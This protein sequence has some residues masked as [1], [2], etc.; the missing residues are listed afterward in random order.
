MRDGI[1]NAAKQGKVTILEDFNTTA[2]TTHYCQNAYP[3]FL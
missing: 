1:T 2:N 3:G